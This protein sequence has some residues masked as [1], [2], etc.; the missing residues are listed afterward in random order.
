MA[1]C[2]HFTVEDGRCTE[3]GTA[4]TITPG[5]S[6]RV[7]LGTGEGGAWV[8]WV[9][10]T[11]APTITQA[12]AL[13][14]GCAAEDVTLIWRSQRSPTGPASNR[15]MRAAWTLKGSRV[16]VWATVSVSDADR[17]D[18]QYTELD[19]DGKPVVEVEAD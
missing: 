2:Y 12:L 3:C 16:T 13:A 7:D 6:V 8:G 4:V 19:E 9:G 11:E 15:Q 5:H 17:R 1:R 14:L 18:P 10:G